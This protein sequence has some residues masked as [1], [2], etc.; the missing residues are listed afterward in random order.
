MPE[1]KKISQ[2]NC[3]EC[4]IGLVWFDLLV[5]LLVLEVFILITKACQSRCICKNDI[6]SIWVVRLENKFGLF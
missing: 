1:F 6:K 5:Y 2:G 3:K 4:F